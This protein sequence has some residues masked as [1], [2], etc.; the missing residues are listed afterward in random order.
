MTVFLGTL[1]NSIKEV[2]PPFVF[3]VE[4]G[5]ALEAMQGNRA[6]SRSEGGHLM[7]ILKLQWEPGISSR[8]MMGM[9]FK[10]LYFL[11]DIRTPV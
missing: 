5:I 6:S 4:H 8:V 1:W 3:D 9:F 11:S 2:K 10:H 7:V